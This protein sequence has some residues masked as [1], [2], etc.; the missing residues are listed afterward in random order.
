MCGNTL[1]VSPKLFDCISN[2]IDKH[3][4]IKLLA[5]NKLELIN[6]ILDEDEI[7]D[8]NEFNIKS[9]HCDEFHKQNIDIQNKFEN[10]IN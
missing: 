4:K 1:L 5:I 3:C 7:I 6:R 9:Y 10:N 8:Q 2:K